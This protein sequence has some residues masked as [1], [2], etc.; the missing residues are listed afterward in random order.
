MI[1]KFLEPISVPAIAGVG[2]TMLSQ[3]TESSSINLGLLLAVGGI[4]ITVLLSAIGSWR[5]RNRQEQDLAA[6]QARQEQKLT[7]AIQK[8]DSIVQSEKDCHSNIQLTFTQLHN[9]I[10]D[11]AKVSADKIAAV[12][13]RVATLQGES[14][15]KPANHHS[16]ATD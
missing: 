5:S 11:E 8:I 15:M 6:S 3:I 9:R 1:T 12:S 2:L 16:R 10:T 4:L 7:D 13:E 14:N